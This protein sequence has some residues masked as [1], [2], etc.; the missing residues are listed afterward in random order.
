[1]TPFQT[2][3]WDPEIPIIQPAAKIGD[4]AADAIILFDGTDINKEWE[5]SCPRGSEPATWV[6][7]DGALVSVQGSG[8]LKTKRKFND[9]QLHIEWKTPSEVPGNGQGRGNSGVYLQ[10]FMKS[11][12]SIASITVHT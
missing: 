1:M 11:R 6:I 9:F 8:S 4:A 5:D 12:Y 7:K 3:L 10:D 2:E